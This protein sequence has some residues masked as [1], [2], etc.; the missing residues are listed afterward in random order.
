MLLI[1]GDAETLDHC[2]ADRAQL[3]HDDRVPLLPARGKP[4]PRRSLTVSDLVV[5]RHRPSL[6]RTHPP[7]T[8]VLFGASG[9]YPLS[10]AISTGAACPRPDHIPG[11]CTRTWVESRNIP[12]VIGSGDRLGRGLVFVAGIQLSFPG[13]E[14]ALGA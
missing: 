3:V 1:I 12:T 11:D 5:T 10:S 6:D 4:G 8:K 2:C 14:G 13:Y 9:Q 7:N